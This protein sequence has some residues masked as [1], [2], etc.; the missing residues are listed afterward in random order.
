MRLSLYE[1][2]LFFQWGCMVAS[3]LFSLTLIGNKR[4]PKYM[5]K[6]YWYSIIVA[7][8]SVY[9]F[10]YRYFNVTN[11]YVS[12]VLHSFLL[13]FHFI[14]LSLFIYSVLPNK[15]ISRFIKFLFF[16]F[17]S[18]LLLCL[19]TIDITIPKSIG[20]AFSNFGL[21]LFCCVYYSQLFE[22]MPTIILIKEPSF[23]IISGVFLCMCTT[24]PLSAIRGYLFNNMPSELYFLMG[25]LGS[26][27]YGV[28]HLFFIKAYLC[29]IS[30]PKA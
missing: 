11:K 5:G 16:L 3:S 20:Y 12:G 7:S 15:N 28:M 21:V 14:F 26:F 27:A 6:F 24:I 18:T 29:S 19:F 10:L 4:I 23:W 13:L 1:I 25:T 8:V 2:F 17:L 22:E 30:Q 9:T